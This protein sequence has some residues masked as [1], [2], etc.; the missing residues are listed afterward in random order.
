MARIYK[1]ALASTS[2]AHPN[3]VMVIINAGL[4]KSKITK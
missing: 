2:M 3:P 4:T 1:R